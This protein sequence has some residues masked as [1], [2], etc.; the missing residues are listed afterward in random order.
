MNKRLLGLFFLALLPTLVQFIAKMFESYSIGLI[1][2][3]ISHIV[4]PV[5]AVA[6]LTNISLKKS[7]FIPLRLKSKKSIFYYSFIFSIG[8]IFIITLAYFLLGQF[9]DFSNIEEQLRAYNITKLTYPLIALAIILINPFL[10]EY[11]WRGFVFRVFDKYSKGYWTGILFALHHVVIVTGWFNWW[12]FLLVT[13]FLSIIGILFN[14]IYKKTDSIYA[15]WII[16]T[17]ADIIIVFI[18]YFVVFN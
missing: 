11:F 18:G 17:V 8:A 4:I 12:Q 10:E 9:V 14:Y 5:F 3:I 15:T 2:R 1:L 16:H 6:Y 13:L 7:F